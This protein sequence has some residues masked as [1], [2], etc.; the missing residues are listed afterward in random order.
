MKSFFKALNLIRPRIKRAT[1]SPWEPIMLQSQTFMRRHPH[2]ANGVK[3]LCATSVGGHGHVRVIDSLVAMALWVRGSETEFLLCDEILPACEAAM[4]PNF[5]DPAEFAQYGPA[6][7]MC[8]SCF[9]G[10][11]EVYRP[12]PIPVRTYSEFVKASEI[13][14]AMETV[15]RLSIQECFH[16]VECGMLLGEQARAGMLRFFGKATFEE[17]DPAFVEAV[18]RRY[19]AGAIITAK[20][21]DRALDVIKPDCIVAHHG[22]YVPQGVLGI[23]AR[24]KGIRVV[25][26]APSYRNTTVIYS[27]GDTYHRTFMDEPTVYWES[28]ELLPHQSKR[29]DE[30]LQMRREGKGDWSWVT[31]DAG[32]KSSIQEQARLIAEL[33]LDI[34]KPIIGLLTNVMWDAQLYYEGT[35]FSSMLDWLFTTMDYFAAHHEIQ[36]IVRIHPHELKAGN[37]QPVGKEIFKRYTRISSNI[38]V[39]PPDS[40]YN[41]Y[42]LMKLCKAVI[43]YGTKTGVEL[44]PLGIPIVVGADAWIRNKG[45]S[46]DPKSREEYMNLL[47][48]LTEFKPLT[49]E[50]ISR[51][52]RYAHHYFFH[53]MISL[54]AIDPDGGSP[55]RLRIKDLSE[56]LPGHDRGLDVVCDGIL[57]SKEFI[58]EG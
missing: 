13:D 38:K 27:H 48:Q 29:L 34:N 46:Y 16:F 5:S 26:W 41:T 25:N 11:S 53:R 35:A 19:L 50:V 36:L 2:K 49:P 1:I 30:Y 15:G 9:A 40:S 56:L 52:R 55:P 31:P 51:A 4:I 7:S 10:G 45:I 33:E 23:V 43:I 32:G 8:A 28:K 3:I 21:F 47:S 14:E 58:C 12:L 37:R 17:D 57:H 22:I 54:G 20:V 24:K 42:G 39:I 18:A 44:A 6:K